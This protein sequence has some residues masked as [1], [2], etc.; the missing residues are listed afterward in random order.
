[1]STTLLG[2]PNQSVTGFAGG[3]SRLMKRFVNDYGAQECMLT[4]N[5]RS[6]QRLASLERVV[7]LELGGDRPR[8]SVRAERPLRA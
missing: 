2:D 5:F 6:S 4:Q 3:D 7:S 8:P 1:M